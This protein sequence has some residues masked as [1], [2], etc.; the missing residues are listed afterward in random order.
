MQGSE[1]LPPS[2]AGTSKPCCAMPCRKLLFATPP[3]ISATLLR[4]TL[5]VVM[6]PHGAQKVLG[7]WKGPG[8]EGTLSS[9]TG[10]GIPTVF[11]YLAIAAE[12]IGPIALAIGLLGRVAAFGIGCV[13]AVAIAM[14]H[15]P[16]GFFMNWAGNQK[17]EGF[18]YHILALGIAVAVMI[19][20]SGA[21]SL[22]RLISGEGRKSCET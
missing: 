1:P 19:K 2:A 3:D 21:F 8:L 20:G 15:A 12:F 4:W 6:F 5:A 22:D 16:N 13:M 7:W 14:V 10:M 18:E 17:G 11:A 9:F